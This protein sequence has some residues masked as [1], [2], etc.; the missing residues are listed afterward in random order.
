MMVTPSRVVFKGTKRSCPSSSPSYPA[1]S[2]PCLEDAM[3]EVN[4]SALVPDCVK[5]AFNSLIH[6]L[7]D[8]R[9]ERDK[10][11]QE[12]L[13]LRQKLGITPDV[14]LSEAEPKVEHSTTSSPVIIRDCIESERL[15][16]LVIA[17]VPELKDSVVRIG[18][19]T[20]IIN[21]YPSQFTD[22]GRH[23][24]NK[25]RLLKVVM[26]SSYFQRLA[27]R[28]A[29][30]LRS[31]PGR[32][33]FLKRVPLETRERAKARRTSSSSFPKNCTSL[34]LVAGG[35]YDLYLFTETWLKK[36][37]SL[38]SMLN[39]W[40]NDYAIL[41]CDRSHR[42]GGGVAILIRETINYSVIISE[43]VPQGYEILATDIATPEFRFRV[44]LA[45]RPPSTS[46][47][48]TEQLAKAISDLA[49]AAIPVIIIGDFNLPEIKW[50]RCNDVE[51]SHHPL[52][53]TFV[54]HGFKQFI[55]EPTRGSNILD[56]LLSNDHEFIKNVTVRSPIGESDHFSICFDI[57]V[58]MPPLIPVLKRL[59]SKCDYSR[60]ATYLFNILWMESFESVPTVEEKYMMFLSILNHSMDT[61]VPWVYVYPSKPNLPPYL[62]NMLDHKECLLRYAKLTGDWNE[63]N[64]FSKKFTERLL[65]YNKNVE[66]NII[67]SKST[68]RFYNFMRSRLR[69]KTQVIYY[70]NDKDKANAFANEFSKTFQQDDNCLPP[71]SHTISS[72]MQTFPHFDPSD[73]Y[74]LL[75]RWPCSHSI[76]PDHIPFIFVRNIAHAI[77]FPLAYI[78]NQS[79]M[80][81]QLG[82]HEKVYKWIGE[83]LTGRTFQ[84][85]I[86]KS[87][88]NIFPFLSG[89]P[90]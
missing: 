47:T 74:N 32:G 44:I 66:K 59:F 73:V 75:M 88:S 8:I 33:V 83:F 20:I 77:A 42:A 48:I 9:E 87:Y 52:A 4:T 17:G 40:I 15:R 46:S 61:F 63:Y 27:V 82:F 81:S 72:T 55:A 24:Q 18:Y 68:Q 79:I 62:Q 37:H 50:D 80:F 45:Y 57:S 21:A 51:E 31:F 54:L 28:R 25:N 43:S 7:I 39:D 64:T 29:P 41:R 30:R 16:S 38:S 70:L 6:E 19:V 56:L 76:T 71:Y 3:R 53:E 5:N 49:A 67:Q 85:R 78:F 14:P 86:N 2:L 34:D 65:K 11:R 23:I 22:L 1:S 58:C 12:N 89:I 60:V 90:Q 36:H 10:L 26:P 35:R 69:K 13:L 84:V